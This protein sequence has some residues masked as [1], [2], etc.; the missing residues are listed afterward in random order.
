LRGTKK[1]GHSGLDPDSMGIASSFVQEPLENQFI[2]SSLR[3]FFEN[4][5]GFKRQL[6]GFNPVH[7]V[8]L[9]KF[10]KDSGLGLIL[11]IL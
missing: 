6:I 1:P 5:L 7:P 8:I 4:E 3:C 2:E 10:L 11:F 9:S